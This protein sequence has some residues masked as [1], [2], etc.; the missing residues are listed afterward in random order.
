MISNVVLLPCLSQIKFLNLVRHGSSA[1]FGT[2]LR[3]IWMSNVTSKTQTLHI[4]SKSYGSHLE[5]ILEVKINL[6]VTMKARLHL[7][8][9]LQNSEK[10]ID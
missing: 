3:H 5:R 8:T 2:G 9:F 1:T 4:I 7:K 6:A 10:Q